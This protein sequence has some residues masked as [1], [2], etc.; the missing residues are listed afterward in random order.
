M[1]DLGVI[2]IDAINPL[3]DIKTIRTNEF[4]VGSPFQ[5]KIDTNVNIRLIMRDA[6]N[7]KNI[8]YLFKL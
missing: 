7:P 1:R 4:F 2:S 3:K 8:L 5:M 6:T